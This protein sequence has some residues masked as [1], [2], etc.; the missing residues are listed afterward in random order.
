[1]NKKY[2]ISILLLAISFLGVI[3]CFGW[4]EPTTVVNNLYT[5]PIN[6]GPVS[7]AKVGTIKAQAFYDY[8]N[9]S[10]YVNPSGSSI[11]S[12]KITTGTSIIPTDDDKTLVTKEYV[13]DVC[14][15]VVYTSTCPEGYF[16]STGVSRGA[17]YIMCCR[18]GS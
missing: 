9:S 15:L 5:T 1:M 2:T 7:Q 6:T 12:G 18:A 16:T 4:F 11:V 8:D 17:G 14:K 13:D 3:V 10:Y